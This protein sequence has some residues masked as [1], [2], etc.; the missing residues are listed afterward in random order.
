MKRAV[1]F[2]SA[3]V[4]VAGWSLRLIR[5]TINSAL[6]ATVLGRYPELHGSLQLFDLVFGLALVAYGEEVVFRRCA[7]SAC[8]GRIKDGWVLI[9]VSSL[10]FAGQPTRGQ[11]DQCIMAPGALLTMASVDRLTQV[12]AS[13]CYARP[14]GPCY[15]GPG[16]MAVTFTSLQLKPGRRCCIVPVSTH[17]E[18][19]S[20]KG[21]KTDLL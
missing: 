6:P 10:L 1:R 20:H 17:P 15:S 8:R 9:V 11:E 2:Y 4:F 12:R 19:R 7:R 13:P 18:Q 16:G 14:G 3:A 5:R 21:A